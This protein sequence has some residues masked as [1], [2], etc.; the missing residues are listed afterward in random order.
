MK[1]GGFLLPPGEGQDEG[2]FTAI[3]PHPNPLSASG[4]RG[5]T[6]CTICR[7]GQYDSALQLRVRDVRWQMLAGPTEF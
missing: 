7:P 1:V 3:S 5:K 6:M 2:S 4:E